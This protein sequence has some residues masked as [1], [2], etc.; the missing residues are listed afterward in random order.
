[1]N[2]LVQIIISLIGGGIVGQLI[3]LIL[4]RRKRK[5]EGIETYSETIDKLLESNS[6]LIQEQIKLRE[7]I[8]RLSVKCP[9]SFPSAVNQPL[10]MKRRIPPIKPTQSKPIDYEENLPVDAPDE[11]P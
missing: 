8:A 2:D 11:P 10:Y 5:T 3:N 4:S 1:M 9:V 6:R 7:H